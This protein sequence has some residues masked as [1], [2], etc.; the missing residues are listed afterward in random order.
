MVVGEKI[1]FYIL[2]NLGYG[3]NGVGLILFFVVLIFDVELLVIE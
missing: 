3:K 1:C 2:S